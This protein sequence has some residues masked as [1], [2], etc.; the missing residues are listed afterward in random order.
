MSDLKEAWMAL[1]EHWKIKPAAEKISGDQ[2][3]NFLR[4][5]LGS[6]FRILLRMKIRGVKNVP[7]KGATILAA[8]HLSHVDQYS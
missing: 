4:W 5:T 7:K 8:N 3:Y 6:F 2:A 1:E